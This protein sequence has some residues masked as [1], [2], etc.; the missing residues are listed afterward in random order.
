MNLPVTTTLVEDSKLSL[1]EVQTKVAEFMI[2]FSGVSN[3]VAA[4][5]LQTTN[6]TSGILNK[7]QNS[8]NQK[9]SGDVMIN[10]LPGWVQREGRRNT[11][12]RVVSHNSAYSY[13]THVPLM[14]YGWKIKRGVI[15][16]PVSITDIAPTISTLLDISFPNSCTG[17]I[18]L[19]LV[20]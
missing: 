3:V 17:N 10:L 14:W 7:I 8:Y 4:H 5:T 2:Q 15:A 16:R 18:I 1:K 13:D 6:Y 11:D 19:E 9:F 20:E 12:S